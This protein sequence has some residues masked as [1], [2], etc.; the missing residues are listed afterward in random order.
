[1]FS[2]RRLGVVEFVKEVLPVLAE[3][4]LE[5]NLM[6]GLALRLA[7]E[8]KPPENAVLCA[9]LEAGRT[10][11]GV[12]WTPPFLAVVS[13]LP[14]GAASVLVPALLSHDASLTGICAPGDHA[15]EVAQTLAERHGSRLE[16][17][18][19]EVQYTL[20][21]VI[22]PARPRGTPR[23][24]TND[25][26]PIVT[27][28]TQ[29]FVDEVRLPHPLDAAAMAKRKV[30]AREAWLWDDDGPK[31]LACKARSMLTGA[32][33]APIYTP[34]SARGRGYASALTAELCQSL[35]D[36]G[37]RFVCLHADRHNPTSNHVYQSIG[38]RAAGEFRVWTVQ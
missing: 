29:G 8:P 3:R 36:A 26:L 2:V 5:N 24:A 4:E 35:L 12:L 32:A 22:A 17:C 27:E 23:V 10:V 15:R 25:D 21:R 11:G 1:M 9:V 19:D 16:L 13:P 38:F 34:P 6:I 28:L 14:A 37:S 18:S 20:T 31:S 33:I 7:A 30:S